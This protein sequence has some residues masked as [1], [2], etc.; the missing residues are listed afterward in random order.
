MP[1]APPPNT[2]VSAVPYHRDGTG[3]PSCVTA[4]VSRKEAIFGGFQQSFPSVCLDF[5]NGGWFWASVY[6][7]VGCL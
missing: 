5:W 7:S 3:G 6:S 2:E 4:H 1:S